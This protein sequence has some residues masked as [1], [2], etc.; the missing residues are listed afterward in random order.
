[1]SQGA[2][3]EKTNDIRRRLS[4]ALDITAQ[5]ETTMLKKP[6]SAIVLAML[7]TFFLES[8]A[9]AAS[10][11]AP[12]RLPTTGADPTSVASIGLVIFGFASLGIGLV[13]YALSRRRST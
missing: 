10:E 12:V 9:M 13:G 8:R 11:M 7:L 6:N 3:G 2:Q 4:C 5:G 1:M